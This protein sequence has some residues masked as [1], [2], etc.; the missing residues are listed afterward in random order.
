M[1]DQ[2]PSLRTILVATDGSDD[3]ALAGLAAADLA[4]RTGAA[5]HLVHAWMPASAASY[6][7]PYM[8][9]TS[10]YQLYQAD[11]AAVLSAAASI[12]AATG[13]QIAA[14]HLHCGQPIGAIVALG[15]ALAA[16]LLV[17]GSR[18]LGPLR[19]LVL[20]SVSSG[21]AQET[22]RPLLVVRG[23]ATAWP[24][25]RVVVGDDGTPAARQA[26][27]LAAA[28]AKLYG[29]PMALVRTCAPL[30]RDATRASE[31][32]FR[33]TTGMAPIGDD[34][35]IV[36]RGEIYGR[37]T[38][39]LHEHAV[40]LQGEGIAEIVTEVIFGD[41]ATAIVEAA[42]AT[43]SPALIAVGTRSLGTLARLRLGSVSTKVLHASPGSVLVVPQ[44]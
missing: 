13:V 8:P 31:D 11:A 21:L 10:A 29:T 17:V 35:A 27:G 7:Y 22:T 24:P 18:G 44:R 26:G 5:L 37:A 25:A 23:G 14:T 39:S 16:D 34:Q 3:A 38:E 19:R 33:S 30:P 4:S 12:L 6:P 42:E 20:G 32:V 9:S 36:M 2:L 40:Q 43:T 1:T 41:P 28:L 15:E